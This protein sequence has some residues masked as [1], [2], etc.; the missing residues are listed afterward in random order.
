MSTTL[1]PTTEL[2]E[3][4]RPGIALPSLRTNVAWTM[5]GNVV[6][7]ACQWFMLVILA[8]LGTTDTVGTFALGLAVAGPIIMLSNLQ[9]RWVQ[10]TDRANEFQFNDCVTLRCLCSILAMIAIVAVCIFTGYRSAT[11]WVITAIAAAKAVESISDVIYGWY[12]QHERMELISHSLMIRGLLSVTAIGLV[13]WWTGSLVAATWALAAA[14]AFALVAF[15]LPSAASFRNQ[16]QAEPFR[17]RWNIEAIKRI[18]IRSLPVGLT[19]GVVALEANIPRYVVEQQLGTGELGIFA[20]MAYILMAAYMI[21]QAVNQSALPRLA[22]YQVERNTIGFRN[23]LWNLVGMGA[24]VGIALV[25]GTALF[26]RVFLHQ[27]Y[28]SEYATRPGILTIIMIG[29]AVMFAFR[30]A[31]VALLS[32]R[33][34]WMILLVHA[35]GLPILIATTCW[36]V[37]KYQLWGAAYAM[38]AQAVIHGVVITAIYVYVAAPTSKQN[39]NPT[40]QTN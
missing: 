33:R 35:C 2:A 27:A 13:F 19:S 20:A 6:Y 18:F 10:A 17:F 14:W 23:V 5:A 9:L 30:P 11:F 38:L 40:V 29:C 31:E 1:I 16:V 3:R 34:F 21:I 32:M 36:L 25:A 12:Q 37:P 39:T 24:A 4:T 15:D 8:K 26:G 7:A 28:G 22:K